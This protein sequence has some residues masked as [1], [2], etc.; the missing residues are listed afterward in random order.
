MEVSLKSLI[1][2][3]IRDSLSEDVAHKTG[4]DQLYAMDYEGSRKTF[5]KHGKIIDKAQQHAA[6]EGYK[7]NVENGHS[8]HK[9]PDVTFH[10]AY[11][12]N[13][14]SAYTVHAKGKAAG[15]K[16]LHQKEIHMGDA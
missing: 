16:F 14:P 8:P 11:G 5:V 10:L 7:V 2:S 4:K 1:E 13:E 6:K 9:Q 3:M 12:D 15:D